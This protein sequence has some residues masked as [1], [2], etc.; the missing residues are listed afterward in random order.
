VVVSSGKTVKVGKKF[1]GSKKKAMLSAE[2]KPSPQGRR[3]I[4]KVD[5]KLKEK[6]EKETL[7]KE[8]IG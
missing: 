3:I 2:T 1:G 7:S 6:I 5:L 8:N 4:P